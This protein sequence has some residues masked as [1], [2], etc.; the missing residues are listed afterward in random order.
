[1]YLKNPIKKKKDESEKQ[2]CV[3]KLKRKKKIKNI[4]SKKLK[5]YVKNCLYLISGLK[6]Q[7]FKFSIDS[8]IGERVKF[9]KLNKTG[10]IKLINISLR[11]FLVP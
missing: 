10:C 6:N 1:M 5:K 4:H 8:I 2:T 3:N 7:Q 11:K 9:Q